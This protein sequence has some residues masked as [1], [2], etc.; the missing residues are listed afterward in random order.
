MPPFKMSRL[1]IQRNISAVHVSA[2]WLHS[3][4]K[5]SFVRHSLGPLPGYCPLVLRCGPLCGFF[6]TVIMWRY[7]WLSQLCTQLNLKAVVKL[8]PEKNSGPNGARTHDLHDID[9]VFYQLSCQANW[10][11]ATLW[12]H[13]DSWS[14]QCARPQICIEIDTN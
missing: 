10:E 7:N 14:A 8:K 6:K 5:A 13:H 2:P 4:L 12:V 9:A 11:L 3:T 1:D